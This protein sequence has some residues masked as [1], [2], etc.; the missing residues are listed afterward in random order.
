MKGYLRQLDIAM[1]GEAVTHWAG[2]RD[3]YEKEV[4]KCNEKSN[5]RYLKYIVPRVEQEL[6]VPRVG[7]STY[8]DQLLDLLERIRRSGNIRVPDNQ[9][10]KKLRIVF[11]QIS[12]D[13]LEPDLVIMDEF[14]RFK[15]LIECDETSDTGMRASRFFNSDSVRMLLLSA[16]PYKMYSTLDE[17]DE[18][19]TDEHYQEFLEVMHF[20]NGSEVEDEKF[21][22][23]WNHYSVKLKELSQGDFTILQ[24]KQ[25]AEDSL[26]SHICRTERISASEGADMIDA[27]EVKTP[28][29]VEPRDITSYLQAQK[30]LDEIGLSGHVPVDYIKSCPYLLSF[31]QKYKLKEDI[32]KY[33]RRNPEQ[34]GKLNRDA[35]WLKRQD[36]LHYGPIDPGNARLADVM[37]H[38]FADG[39]DKLLW[40]PPSRPYYAPGGAYSEAEHFTKTLIFSSWE[41]VPRM[42]SCMLSYEAERRTVGVLA[43]QKERKDAKYFHAEGKRFPVARLNFSVSK[44]EAGAMTLFCLLYPSKFLADCYDPLDCMNRGLS[45]AEIQGEI[46]EKI[47]KKLASRCPDY[48]ATDSG[49]EDKKWYY[50]APLLMDGGGYVSGWLDNDKKLSEFEDEGEK[51]KKGFLTHLKELRRLYYSG[52]ALGKVPENLLDV[53]ATMAIASPAVCAY[54]TYSRYGSLKFAQLYMPSIVAKIFMNHMNT[55]ESTAIIQLCYGESEDAHW[56]NLLNYCK[57]G[58]LQAVFD[59]Y[60]HLLTNG[61]ERNETLLDRLHNSVTGSMAIRTVAYKVDTYNS[62]K[63]HISGQPEKNVNVRTHFAVSFTKGIGESNRDRKKVVRNAFNSPFRPFVLAT[64]S[65]GQEGLDFHNYCRRIVHWNLPSNP[66]DLEQR[67]G[68]INR[69][70]C[71]AIRQ[72][73]ADRYGN[74]QFHQDIWQEMFAE[75]ASQEKTAGS[76]DLIPYW[77]LTERENMVRIERIVPMY[78]FSR[79]ELSYERLIKILS[80]Y[81]LTL[82]QARQEELLEYLFNNVENPEKL[83]DLFINLSPFYKK[84]SD[85]MRNP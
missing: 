41:M 37:A 20:L 44:G 5:G 30:L 81:R 75:A 53:L 84:M 2:I 9:I 32:E 54:R 19:Q 70:E 38:A 66:I 34:V 65:I 78:P 3:N 42:I 69:F 21:R 35:L 17:I 31:M 60:A 10:I 85:K 77:G 25:E 72:N 76:S 1:M 79:D 56:L 36:F 39:A 51:R 82:G 16:T 74:I 59:E 27:H 28:V 63:A 40:V 46:K 52:E 24:A 68:R 61:Q 62:F 48:G 45:L 71:L 49:N 11:A 73:V 57:D 50:M 12:L 47:H 14:Q 80:L 13:K 15:F 4:L 22:T 58:N 55:P 83:K 67:E 29:K 8:L 64:T 6:T 33:F 23:V 7:E 26:Y 43:E 18:N